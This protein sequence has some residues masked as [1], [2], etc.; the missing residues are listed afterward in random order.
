MVI[1]VGN[2]QSLCLLLLKV[3][4]TNSF[5]FKRLSL[6]VHYL[7]IHIPGIVDVLVLF[8]V[9]KIERRTYSIYQ[10]NSSDR[11][12]SILEQ[13]KVIG[14]NTNHYNLLLKSNNVSYKVLLV[15]Y[16]SYIIH[17]WLDVQTNR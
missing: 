8:F 5:L 17:I 9:I 10:L 11:C 7:N 2:T 3:I 16:A 1:Y 4:V 6:K 12:K 14:F 13:C 15:R